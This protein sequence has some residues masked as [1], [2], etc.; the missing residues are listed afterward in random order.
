MCRN[1]RVLHNFQ[2]PTTP[3]EIHAAA[4]QFVRKVSGTTKPPQ[5]DQQAFE[6]AVTEV[7]AI[8]EKLLASLTARAPVRTREGEQEKGRKRWMLRE[9]RMRTRP[10][11]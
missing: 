8:T 6:A 10:P 7:A 11:E 5:A 2:P 9:A 3:T 1:I 4:L